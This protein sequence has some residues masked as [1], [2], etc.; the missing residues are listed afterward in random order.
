LEILFKQL[1]EFKKS[2]FLLLDNIKPISIELDKRSKKQSRIIREGDYYKDDNDTSIGD[3]YAL[4]TYTLL[5]FKILIA[6]LYL[7]NFYLF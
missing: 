2:Y 5:P 4:T 7:S 1:K 6:F 3:L